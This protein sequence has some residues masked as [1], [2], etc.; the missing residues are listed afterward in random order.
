[1]IGVGVIG[2]GQMGILHGAISNKIG[3]S[4]LVAICDSDPQ[5]TKI[6]SKIL[7]RIHFYEDSIEMLTKESL[8]AI[9]VCTPANTH[10]TIVREVVKHSSVRGIFVEKPIA[11]SYDEA[12]SMAA[13]SGKLVTSVGFQKRQAGTFAKAKQLLDEEIFGN[14]RFFRSHFY[15]NEI[16]QPGSGWKFQKGS[17]GVLL[18]FSPH[19]LDLLIWYFGEPVGHESISKSLHSVQVQDYVHTMLRYSNGL[20]GYSD[21]CW[22]MRNYSPGELMVEIHGDNGSMMVNESRLTLYLDKAIGDRHKQGINSYFAPELTPP[23]PFLIGHPENV[24][25]DK[26]FIEG[27]MNGYRVEPSFAAGV[28]VNKLIDQITA[29]SQ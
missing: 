2:A 6:G 8:D 15:T 7:P 17:G 23:V 24:L 5:L 3:G 26:S 14:L 4:R 21:V 28:A 25:L 1:M 20:V 22:G 18:E 9:F 10:A 27:T 29:E 19:L 11:T 13:A 16:V 12:S